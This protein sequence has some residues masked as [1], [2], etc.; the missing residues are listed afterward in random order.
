[1]FV[2][3]R[4]MV[5]WSKHF[6]TSILVPMSYVKHWN[7]IYRPSFRPSHVSV[8]RV[9]PV[10]VL[11]PCVRPVIIVRPMSVLCPSRPVVRPVVVNRPLSVCP[12]V[13][14]RRRRRPLSLCLSVLGV[15]SFKIL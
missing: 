3:V 14:R 2:R 1:M 12:V 8:P 6:H 5:L 9:R 10:V 7:Y 4:K 15:S 11:C 13:S